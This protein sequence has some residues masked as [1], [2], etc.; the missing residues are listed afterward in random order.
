M[1]DR[2]ISTHNAA[3]WSVVFA[4]FALIFLLFALQFSS[5][6]LEIV[7]ACTALPAILTVALM[8]RRQ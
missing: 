7:I 6:L 4:V 3:K 8:Q 2:T 5:S 1:K